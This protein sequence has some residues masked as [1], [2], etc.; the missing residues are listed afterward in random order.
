LETEAFYSLIEEVVSRIREKDNLQH[1]KWVQSQ[2]VMEMLGI[3]SKSTLQKL[4]DEGKIRFS[5]PQKRIILYDYPKAFYLK[6]T[7]NQGGR[8]RV[9][10][11]E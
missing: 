9:I 1:D 6:H 4:R 3:K 8:L 7:S 5:Q 2:E 10:L 11:M